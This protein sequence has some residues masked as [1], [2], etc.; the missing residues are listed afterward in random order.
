MLLLIVPLCCHIGVCVQVLTVCALSSGPE[1]QQAV[2]NAF[3]YRWCVK[4]LKRCGLLPA[5]VRHFNMQLCDRLY[6]VANELYGNNNAVLPGHVLTATEQ[7]L[8]LQHGVYYALQAHAA[9]LGTENR[10]NSV[11]TQSSAQNAGPRKLTCST[12]AWINSC[13]HRQYSAAHVHTRMSERDVAMLLQAHNHGS[14]ILDDAPL[15]AQHALTNGLFMTVSNAK[16][17]GT[18]VH[19]D[20]STWHTMREA[21]Y[22]QLQQRLLTDAAAAAAA[23]PAGLLADV[24]LQRTDAQTETATVSAVSR[25]AE[26]TMTT[27]VSANSTSSSDA[28]SETMLPSGEG[29]STAQDE[30][31]R[32]RRK[33]QL[34]ESQRRSRDVKEAAAVA[35]GA[36]PRK[37]RKS[38]C[39]EDAET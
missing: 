12:S 26:S 30:I 25:P 7:P 24:I 34:R 37:R 28:A 2:I 22:Y 33:R 39:A 36:P 8:V 31:Q 5:W 27:S 35:A 29:S 15:L 1:W 13:L 18:R 4:A 16:S 14:L 17:F 32:E 9:M 11:T 6:S 10:A 21:H 19:V 23:A 38:R 3:D 20:T